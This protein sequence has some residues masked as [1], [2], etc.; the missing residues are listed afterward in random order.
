VWFWVGLLIFLVLVASVLA[1]TSFLVEAQAEDT[2][3]FYFQKAP[4]PV[5]VN[6]GVMGQTSSP[7]SGNPITQQPTP[8]NPL[9]AQTNSASV[10]MPATS[11]S[12]PEALSSSYGRKWELSAGYVVG[13][14][15]PGKSYGF[16]HGQYRLGLQM[17]ISDSF[18]L[19]GAAYYLGKPVTNNWE[20]HEILASGRKTD[21]SAGIVV[22]PI[23]VAPG[24]PLVGV[25]FS[26]LAGGISLPSKHLPLRPDPYGPPDSL[27][28]EIR[29]S[30]TFYVGARA[31]LEL[32]NKLAL[33]AAVLRTTGFNMTKGTASLAYHF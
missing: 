7:N 31:A 12:A 25:S 17:N 10:P 8:G 1:W 3:N 27:H 23:R 13:W 20:G 18:A 33:Q 14:I 29:H 21:W 5:T 26:G 24:S 15:G 28:P 6:Q 22:T 9:Q 30:T 11:T 19:E 4:G 2:Y 32:G 16:L